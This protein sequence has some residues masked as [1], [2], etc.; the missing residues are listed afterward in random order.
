MRIAIIAFVLAL[1]LA[2]VAAGD[3]GPLVPL[4]QQAQ[5]KTILASFG[6]Q[7]LEY[8]PTK[9]PAHYIYNA[10][11]VN[12]TENLITLADGGIF[13]YFTVQFFNGKLN[14]CSK[15]SQVKITVAGVTIF[16]RGAAVWRCLQAPG[17]KV[18][19]VGGTGTGLS[20]E[21][22]GTMIASAKHA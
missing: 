1:A 20:R 17:G 8:V 9:A 10:N 4:E 22:L 11:V 6:F 18:V 19:K 12:S 16:S 21:D 5:M 3:A 7:D 15:G 13:T 2:P 14:S